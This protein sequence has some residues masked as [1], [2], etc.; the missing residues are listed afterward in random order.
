M[1]A[2]LGFQKLSAAYNSRKSAPTKE[3]QMKKVLIA[4]LLFAPVVSWAGKDKPKPNPADFSITV[5]VQSSNLVSL[6]QDSW[7]MLNP[8]GLGK[9]SHCG[10][11]QH[12]VA[13]VNGKKYEL[14]SVDPQQLALRIGDYKAKGDDNI[15]P[16]AYEYRIAFEIL[17]PDGTT[18]MY[19]VV[20]GS[21]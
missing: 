9:A 12:L 10:T 18:R 8:G 19:R 13:L 14:D 5:H 11:V 17:F 2:R 7:G 21:E 16:E 4:I 3:I 1:A 6:C 15:P 20:G